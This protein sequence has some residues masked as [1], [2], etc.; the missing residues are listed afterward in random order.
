MDT[1]LAQALEYSNYK[2]AIHKLKQALKLRLDN[3]LSYAYNGGL[4]K[5][6]EQLISFVDVMVKRDI[7]EMVLIDSRG[8]PIQVKDLSDFLDTIISLY[9]ESTNEYHLNFSALS[10]A[11]SVKQVTGL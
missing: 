9:V 10:K 4:F 5:I 1:R 3:L 2:V 11:R 6:T 8:N 7:T